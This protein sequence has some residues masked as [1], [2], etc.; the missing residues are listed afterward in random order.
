[1]LRF[2]LF[3]GVFACFT[4]GFSQVAINLSG[5]APNSNAALD[6]DFTDKGLLPPRVALSATNNASPL[7]GH[8]AGMVVYNTAT[9]GDVTPGMYYN[10]GSAWVSMTPS[11]GGCASAPAAPSASTGVGVGTQLTAT[12][13]ASSTATEYYLDVATDAGFTTFVSG[14]NNRNVGNATQHIISGL[15]MGTTYRYRVRAAN[16]CGTSASSSTITYVTYALGTVGPS[17]AG[18]VVYDK[19]YES[20]GWRYMEITNTDQGTSAWCDNSTT[21]TTGADGNKEGSGEL[22]T[23]TMAGFCGSGA[24]NTCNNLV[25]GGFSNWFLPSV[26]EMRTAQQWKASAVLNMEVNDDWWTSTEGTGGAAQINMGTSA[27][28]QGNKG[29]GRRFRCARYF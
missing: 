4:Q 22:N 10:N 21:I 7:S 29:N 5:S 12:W 28:T 6:V 13:S 25:L 2:I 23:T 24:G 27:V 15:T 11:G 1:M 26:E 18:R 20:S 8:V 14:Y 17:G 16:S 9:A 19:G 3:F